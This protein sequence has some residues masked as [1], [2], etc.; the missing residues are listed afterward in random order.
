MSVERI[1]HF[2]RPRTFM[3]DLLLLRVSKL[4]TYRYLLLSNFFYLHG[5]SEFQKK[6]SLTFF[7]LFLPK[8]K[9]IKTIICNVSLFFFN[10]TLYIFYVWP[11]I[12]HIF[13]IFLTHWRY[14]SSELH[15]G[16]NERSYLGGI[17]QWWRLWM[18]S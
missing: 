3:M 9:S 14:G 7:I 18:V 11:T 8:W 6:N 2:V 1:A 10:Q 15:W 13:S 5:E 16:C 17:A 4:R 12:L